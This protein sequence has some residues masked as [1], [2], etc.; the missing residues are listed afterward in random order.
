MKS[1][2]TE[3]D[4]GAGGEWGREGRG[5]QGPSC[6]TGE[7]ETR[8]LAIGRERAARTV[9]KAR[10]PRVSRPTRQ[11][12]QGDGYAGWRGAGVR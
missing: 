12:G 11:S 2:V 4:D 8:L 3:W 6:G 10:V 5:E 9:R 7:A 1:G